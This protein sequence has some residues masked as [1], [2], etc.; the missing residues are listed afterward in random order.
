MDVVNVLGRRMGFIKD[1]LIDFNSEE[2]KGF[3]MSSYK[4]YNKNQYILNE[5]VISFNSVMIVSKTSE[6]IF[7]QFEKIKN[8]DIFDRKG[9]IIGITEDIIFNE[10]DYK[11]NGLIVSTG[12]LRNFMYGKNIFLIRE[13]ILGDDN[14]LYI[15]N[16]NNCNFFST[17]H[18]IATK[19]EIK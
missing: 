16:E 9:N 17:V 14:L 4:I 2:I 7:L 1:V 3:V 13:L 8:M 18:K 12:I 11:I 15:G 5:N 6:N 19:V 10:E